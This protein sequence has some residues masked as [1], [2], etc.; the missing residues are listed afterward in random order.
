M[1]RKTYFLPL[2]ASVMAGLFLVFSACVKHGINEN[3]D[4]NNQKPYDFMSTRSG[5]YWHYGSR[6]GISYRRFARNMDSVKNGLKFSYYERQEDTGAGLLTPEYF[7]KNGTYYVTLLDLENNG[8]VPTP[9]NKY[10]E[11]VFW[12]DDAKQGTSWQNTGM[13][14]HPSVGD[15]KLYTSSKEMSDNDTLMLDTTRYTGVVHVHSDIRTVTLNTRIG[16]LD[17]WFIKNIG[18]L[19]EEAHINIL[20]AYVQDHTD[21]LIDYHIEK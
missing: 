10:L 14:Y 3:L 13:V 17:M 21:S 19:K 15:V 5:S 6:E 11:Y 8:S 16:T 1:A 7:G 2:I 18:V 9:D 4:P 12:I 20:G